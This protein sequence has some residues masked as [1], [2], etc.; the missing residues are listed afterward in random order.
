MTS[1]LPPPQWGHTFFDKLLR[2]LFTK[3]RSPEF[4]FMFGS[5][6]SASMRSADLL[7]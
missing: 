6:Y 2:L 1:F 7:F 3:L 4:Q 5:E